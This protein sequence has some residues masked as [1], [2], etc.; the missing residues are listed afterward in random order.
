M[1]ELETTPSQTIGPFFH[2][3][4]P[5]PDGSD[6]VPEGTP[7]AIIVGIRVFDGAG[8]PVPDSLV[9]TWQA[10]PEG[11]FDH[12]DDIRGPGRSGFRGFGRCPADAGGRTWFRT[13]MPGPLPAEDGLVE[14]PHIDVSVFARGMLHRVVTRVYFPDQAEANAADPVLASLPDV[15]RTKLVAKAAPGGYE[16]EVHLQGELE[17]PFFDL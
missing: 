5:W 15:D 4:L 17:T 7:S 14:A 2:V 13:L 10:D 16:F 12:P 6:V 9:E 3:V 1:T 11:R 8:T